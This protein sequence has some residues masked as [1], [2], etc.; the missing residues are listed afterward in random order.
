MCERPAY[1]WKTGTSAEEVTMASYHLSATIIK[2][3]AGRSATAAAAY[4]AGVEIADDRTGE[5]HDYTRKS[6]VEHTAILSPDNAPEWTQDRAA[7]WNAVEAAE[8]RKDAQVAREITVALPSG[9]DREDRRDLVESW[10]RDNLTEKGMIA[11]I[12]IHE[13]GREG[14][15]RNHH[16]HILVTTREVG[17]D[18]FGKKERGWNDTDV[19]KEWRET[20]AEAQND[21][22]DRA[23]SSERVDHRSLEAQQAEAEEAERAARE[24]GEVEEADRQAQRAMELDRTAEPKMGVHVTGME[25]R[26]KWQAEREGREYAPVTERGAAVAQSRA[27]RS[28]VVEA[29]DRMDAARDAYSQARE[30]GRNVPSAYKDALEALVERTKVR[31][32]PQRQYRS[33]KALAELAARAASK[34]EPKEALAEPRSETSDKLQE[35]LR[36][37]ERQ[38]A[39]RVQQEAERARQDAERVRQ[40]AEHKKTEREKPLSAAQQRRQDRERG[41]DR[42]DGMDR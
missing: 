6:G 9:L 29:R 25:R 26:A 19:L 32:R 31:D 5:V 7:L 20:W 33:S 34:S 23:G 16:A 3:S 40:E 28:M 35:M 24:R 4:R 22:L 12:A 37:Q 38:K 11:D 17:P 10:T 8:K 2:R 1:L 41:V 18:G 27:D 39:E 30:E 36:E 13:P 14:D 15:E 21:A 42:D